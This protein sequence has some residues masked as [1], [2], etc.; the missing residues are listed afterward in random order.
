M[1]AVRLEAEQTKIR[2]SDV[3]KTTAILDLP[4]GK[5]GIR[6]N[7][8][9]INSNPSPWNWWRKRSALPSRLERCKPHLS[10]HR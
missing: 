9:A 3:L 6:G 7:S 10:R 1:Q 4:E 2:L 8:H 5:G